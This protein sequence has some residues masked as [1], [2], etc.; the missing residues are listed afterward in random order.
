MSLP[1]PK[2]AEEISSKY[3]PWTGS[4]RYSRFVHNLLNVRRTEVLD[5]ILEAF[6]E[7]QHVIAMAANGVGKSFSAINA[8]LGGTFCNPNTTTNI[9]SGSY[10]QLDDTIWKPM[11]GLHRNS[12]LPG[13]T[14]DN[15]REL[16][17]ELHEEWYAKCLSPKHPGDL[18]GRHNDR[19][20]YVIEE[21]DKPGVS[22]EHID[23]ALSTLTDKDDRILV[24]CN[25]PEDETNVVHDLWES[26]RWHNLNF[27]SWD[28]HDCKVDLGEIDGPKI[29]GLADLSKLK[30]DW[31]EFNNEDWPGIEQAKKWSTPEHEDFRRDLDSRWYRRRAGIMPPQGSEKW[32]PFSVSDVEAAWN[33]ELDSPDMPQTAAVD[34][35]RSGDDTVISSK[36][37]SVIKTPYARQGYNHVQQ[38]EDILDTLHRLDGPETAVDAVGEGS[39]LADELNEVFNITRYSNGAKPRQ[40]SEYYNCWAEALDMFGKF[41]ESGS[42]ASKQLYEQAAVAARVIE[43]TEKDLTSRGGGVIKANSK[44]KIKSELGHSPDYLDAALMA[45]WIDMAQTKTVQYRRGNRSRTNT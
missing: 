17:T 29:G 28:S 37:E 4:D 2:K 23:S 16:R 18:E 34:V 39:G 30:A 22:H 42:I 7:N 33:R 11:K 20:L 38:K 25:P 13:R 24:I 3:A 40:E 31:G 27:A 44:E 1:S 14:L 36:H 19:M 45:N 32:R 12:P 43:F 26:D 21:A 15:T 41:L 10:G 35:A 8:A 6:E 5:T 9:T